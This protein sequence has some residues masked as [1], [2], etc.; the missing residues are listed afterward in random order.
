MTDD[1]AIKL[2]TDAALAHL[3][4]MLVA[5]GKRAAMSFAGGLA[6]AARN[7]VAEHHGARAAYDLCQG[8]ADDVIGKE[9]A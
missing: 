3:N 4:M 1:A 9:A 6:A 7:H 8:L 5:Y 2:G